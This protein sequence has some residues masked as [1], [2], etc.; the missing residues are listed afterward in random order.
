MIHH[1]P[2][3]SSSSPGTGAF[4]YYSGHKQQNISRQEVKYLETTERLSRLIVVEDN[5]STDYVRP[6]RRHS[7]FQ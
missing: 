2:V 6:G 5:K 7:D 3:H 4:T 1:T